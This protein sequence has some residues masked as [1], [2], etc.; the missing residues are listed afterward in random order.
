MASN[1]AVGLKYS[2]GTPVMTV[3]CIE[4]DNLMPNLQS[5]CI[6]VVEEL[7]ILFCNNHTHIHVP[8]YEDNTVFEKKYKLHEIYAIELLGTIFCLCKCQVP[9]LSS[10]CIGP[11]S[12]TFGSF[13]FIG[14]GIMCWGLN[15][16]WHMYYYLCWQ[17]YCYETKLCP[18]KLKL[19][20][21]PSWFFLF[22]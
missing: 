10:R 19:L 12:S 15:I 11:L 9:L 21:M 4:N 14:R 3:F 2:I 17:Q 5:F 22:C 13:I 7:Y 1:N 16:L 6:L 18:M 8:L 20:P